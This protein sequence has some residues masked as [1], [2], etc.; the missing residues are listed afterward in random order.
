VYHGCGSISLTSV[1]VA[2]DGRPSCAT[3]AATGAAARLDAT[4][5]A[6]GEGP[7]IDAVELDSV[8]EVRADDLAADGSWPE[9]RA[10]ACASGVRSTLSI[11]VPWTRYHGAGPM[12]GAITLYAPDAHAFVESEAVGL[13][14]GAWAGSVL[15]G[16]EPADV[17]D[18][19]LCRP[20]DI[21][22]GW[23]V[24]G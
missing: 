9:L 6:L 1:H 12:V 16:E 24:G 17:Y 10:V 2:P 20:R 7:T 21:P 19:P 8:A 14:L 22:A 3:V 15:T 11:S 13:L 4:Q 18:A 23:R 5:Y